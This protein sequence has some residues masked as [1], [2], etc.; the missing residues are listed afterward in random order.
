MDFA[1]STPAESTHC[2]RFCS[3][4]PACALI[5]G[6]SP[7]RGILRGWTTRTWGWRLLGRLPNKRLKLTGG[8]RFKGSGVLCGGAHRLTPNDLAPADDSPAGA[9][10]FGESRCAPAHKTPLPLKR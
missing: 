2:S 10:S 9:R 1:N 5:L 3:R 7:V 6:P 4:F 8:D